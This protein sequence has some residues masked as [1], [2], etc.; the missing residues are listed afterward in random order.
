MALDKYGQS[1]TPGWMPDIQ[2]L[3]V[4][5]KAKLP[6]RAYPT[7]AGADLYAAESAEI[8]PGEGRLIDTG[9]AVKIPS[10]S[11]GFIDPRSSMRVAGLTC[12][13]TGLIDSD[14]RNTL[15]VFIHNMGN[16]RLVIEQYVTRIGQLTIVPI[17]L[18]AFTDIWNDTARGMGGFGSTGK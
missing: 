13:G 8:L 16:D 14:Y 7:D 1:A 11:A 18:P 2:C 10:G 4:D 9:I 6:V 15:K 17:M 5:P 3:R 12:H